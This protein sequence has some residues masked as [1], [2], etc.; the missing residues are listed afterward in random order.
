MFIVACS[1]KKATKKRNLIQKNTCF[2]QDKPFLKNN[3]HCKPH[4]LS[5]GAKIYWNYSCDSSWLT[6]ENTKSEKKILY[7]LDKE[8]I[9]LTNRIGP[10]VLH[11][12]KNSFLYEYAVISGCCDPA[13]SYLYDKNSGQLIKQFGRSIFVSSDTKIPILVGIKNS[14]YEENTEI[15]MSRLI[16]YNFDTRKEFEIPFEG[17]QIELGCKNN[18]YLF[19]EY[20]FHDSEISSKKLILKYHTRNSDNLIKNKKL[21]EKIFKINLERY[22]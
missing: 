14:D 18:E 8:L 2:C 5:N 4:F 20:V 21:Q 1:P 19:P 15:D 7:S 22:L 10:V 16:L 9:E 3:I 17:D 13:I 11:E 6:F 12:F